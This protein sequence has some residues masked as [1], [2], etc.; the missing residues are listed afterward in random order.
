MS[1]ARLV[2]RAYAR[3]PWVRCIGIRGCWGIVE[4]GTDGFNRGVLMAAMNGRAPPTGVCAS[5]DWTNRRLSGD[6]R[7]ADLRT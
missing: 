3:A 5:S 7:A 1:L 4:H 6:A 2:M